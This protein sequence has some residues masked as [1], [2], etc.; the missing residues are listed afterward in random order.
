MKHTYKI[1]ASLL[2]VVSVF[3]CKDEKATGEKKIEETLTSGTTTILVDNTV[4]PAVDDILQVFHSVYP[5]AHI[6][7]VNKSE[8]EVVKDLVENKAGVAVMSRLLTDEENAYFVKRK[9]TPQITQFASDAVAF[10]TNKAAKDT[11]VELNEILKLVKGQTSDKVQKLV[12]DNANSSTVGVLLNIAGV[13]QLPSQNIYSL[14]TNEEVIRYVH[15]N[16]GSIGVVGVN[17]LSQPTAEMSKI[18]SDVTVLAVDN[19][20]IDKS[21]KRYYKPTQSNIATGS[22]PLI[23][24]VYML[25]Y[26]GKDGLGMGFATYIGAFE[27]QRIILKTG[28]LPVKLPYREIEVTN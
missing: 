16:P 23:R 22:Y 6:T 8:T 25:N 5:R 28:L 13:K 15:D 27:G 10:I 11:V 12:F 24:K 21:V 2:I 1:F 7:L 18:V 20:K 26:S 3:S 4:E 14:K 9:I 17:W 19:V